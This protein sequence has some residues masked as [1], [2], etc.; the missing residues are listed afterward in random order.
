MDAFNSGYKRGGGNVQIVNEK[1][2]FDADPKVDHVNYEYKRG[3]GNRQVPIERLL[4]FH[5][6]QSSSSNF[7]SSFFL[8]LILFVRFLM[9]KLT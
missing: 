9:R 5:L 3:G 4:S 8:F 1:V 2:A 6:I 7:V